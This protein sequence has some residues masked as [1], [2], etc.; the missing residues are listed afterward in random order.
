MAKTNAR[1]MTDQMF[2]FCQGYVKRGFKDAPGAYLEAYPKCGEKAAESSASRTLRNA[3]VSAYLA[4]VQAKAQERTQITAD[5]VL[6]ELGKLGF[7][8][9]RDYADWGPDGVTLKASSGMEPGMTAAVCEVTET[10]GEKG[11][12]IKFKLHDKRA[13]LEL[14]GKHFGMFTDRRADEY[15]GEPAEE[16]TPE[17][18]VSL[19]E[20]VQRIKTVERFEKM[21]VAASQKQMKQIGAPE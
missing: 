14:I 6:A 7:A 4:E 17:R 10:V 21:L 18:M 5:Q 12:S 19:W 2:L 13:A 9:M 3:K 11:G 16:M 20:R 8:D 1:G 15:G